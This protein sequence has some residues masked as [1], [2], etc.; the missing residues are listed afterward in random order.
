[1]RS[2]RDLASLLRVVD[3]TK[4]DIREGI[5]NQSPVVVSLFASP[6]ILH[7]VAPY[8]YDEIS[9][10]EADQLSLATAGTAEE[11][12]DPPVEGET[13][14]AVASTVVATTKSTPSATSVSSPTIKRKKLLV[15]RPFVNMRGHT[16]FLT[17]ATA[18]NLPQPDPNRK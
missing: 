17:F 7:T 9:E 18:G 16:A 2:C 11:A 3:F 10:N 1:M 6:N 13:K 4:T 15:A 8:K 12:I 14:K 5:F